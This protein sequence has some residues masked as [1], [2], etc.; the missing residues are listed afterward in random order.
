MKPIERFKEIVAI[1]FG[2]PMGIDKA[3]KQ[4]DKEYVRK[5]LLDKLNNEWND[6]IKTSD[7]FIKDLIDDRKKNYIKISEVVK[8][9]EMYPFIQINI[10]KT[11]HQVREELK[12]KFK[13]R[14]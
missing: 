1:F 10:T 5:E 8:I 3:L 14:K 11:V 9:I 7:L 13:D 2:M 6:S 4:L 12:Q